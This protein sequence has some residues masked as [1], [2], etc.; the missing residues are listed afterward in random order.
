MKLGKGEG[1]R[2]YRELVRQWKSG[3][4]GRRKCEHSYT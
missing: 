4:G 3:K 2:K 1:K